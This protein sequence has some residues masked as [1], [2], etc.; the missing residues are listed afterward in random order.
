MKSG[1]SVRMPPPL[2]PPMNHQTL[3]V[4]SAVIGGWPSTGS[5]ETDSQRRHMTMHET[6]Q[7]GYQCPS[8]DHRQPVFRKAHMRSHI[9]VE[10]GGAAASKAW[11][12]GKPEWL[13]MGEVGLGGSRTKKTESPRLESS[14]AEGAGTTPDTA[15]PSPASHLTTPDYAIGISEDEECE[16]SAATIERMLE[17]SEGGEIRVLSNE[18]LNKLL[19][20]AQGVTSTPGR[21]TKRESTEGGGSEGKRSHTTSSLSPLAAAMERRTP[22]VRACRLTGAATSSTGKGTPAGQLMARME[23]TPAKEQR[24]H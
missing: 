5:Q 14:P 9:R 21:G 24:I 13:E 11:K 7:L 2:T 3:Y 1:P 19:R 6:K 8:C 22:A 10:H 4:R 12:P 18:E 17:E 20:Q 15:E 16:I 23:V